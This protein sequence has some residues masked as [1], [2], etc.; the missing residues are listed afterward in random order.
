MDQYRTNKKVIFLFMLPAVAIYM[1]LA[2]IPIVQSLYFGFF[3]WPGIQ[4]VELK[5]VGL[6]NFIDMFESKE[7]LLSLRNVLQYMLLTLVIQI[8]L[9]YGLAILLGKFYKGFKLY[10]VFYFFPVVLPLTAT[11]LLWSFIFFPNDTGVLNMVL[12][13][14]GLENLTTAWLLNPH[15][16]LNCITITNVWAGF[17][18]H[19]MIG[20]AA[21][22]S[23]PEQILESAELD[24]AKGF[25]KLRYIILPIIW[26][27]VKISV[28][29]IV[30]GNLKQFDM[31][32]V[33]TGGGPNGLTQLPATLMYF[34]AFRYNHYGL[35]SAISAFLFVVCIVLAVV[36]MKAME[37]EKIEY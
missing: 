18:Y 37:R 27:S 14:L 1:V 33:M 25:K 8:P 4:G 17:G 5:F 12:N 26:E 20:F 23:I 22:T 21:L 36:S 32:F 30:T 7:F 31:V 35:G 9:A 2:V 19:M 16:A 13:A 11:S 24:G 29:L 28:V 10:K 15:T 6:Q 34:E 3:S